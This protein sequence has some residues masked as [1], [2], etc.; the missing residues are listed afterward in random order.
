MEGLMGGM[1]CHMTIQ[2]NSVT[3]AEKTQQ[4][5]ERAADKA[6]HATTSQIDAGGGLEGE[7]K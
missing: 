7:F 5:M 1:P 6:L 4:S 2:V 3:N